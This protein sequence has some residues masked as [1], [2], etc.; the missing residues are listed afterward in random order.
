M[1]KSYLLL[2]AVIFTAMV[3]GQNQSKK[4]QAKSRL[5]CKP[6]KYTKTSKQVYFSENFDGN[7]PPT[8]WI[9]EPTTGEGQWVQDD[10]SS[11]G[12]GNAFEGASAAMFNNYYFSEGVEGSMTTPALDLST[13]TNPLLQ[14]YWWNNDEETNPASLIISI[15]TDGAT[16]TQIDQIDVFGCEETSWVRYQKNIDKNITHIKITGVSDYGYS[17]TFIDALTIEEVPTEAIAEL[18]ISEANFGW[19]MANTANNP[20]GN[21]FKL[22]NMGLTD[23]SISSITDLSGTDF[24]STFDQSVSLAL[25]ETHEF[26]FTYTPASEGDDAINFEIVTNGGTVSINLTGRGYE[27]TEGMVECGTGDLIDQGLPFYP[28]KNYSYTQSI[29]RQSE[30]NTANKQIEKLYYHFN[31]HSE[32]S[33]EITIYMGH[34]SSTMLNEWIP[35]SELTCVFEGEITT[36]NEDNFIEIT[37]Q[38]PFEYNNSDHLIIAI[39][40]NS[41]T[42]VS[43]DNHFYCHEKGVGSSYTVYDY[44]DNIDPAN[45]GEGTSK[46]TCANMRFQFEPIAALTQHTISGTI[47]DANNGNPVANATI[48]AGIFSTQTSAD[49]TY[50]LNVSE[51]DYTLK[52]IHEDF[53]VYSEDIVVNQDVSKS[54]ALI[55]AIVLLHEGFNNASIPPAGWSRFMRGNIGGLSFGWISFSYAYEGDFSMQNYDFA[56]GCDNWI[57]TPK[58]HITENTKLNYQSADAKPSCYVLISTG[59]PNPDDNQFKVLKTH[60]EEWSWTKKEIDLSEYAGMD[61]YIAFRCFDEPG[62]PASS[63]MVDDV[64]IIS[65]NPSAKIYGTISVSEGNTDLSKA[66][67]RIGHQNIQVNSDGSFESYLIPGTYTAS[68]KIDAYSAEVVENVSVS[69]DNDNKLDISLS[70]RIFKAPNGLNINSENGEFSWNTPLLKETQQELVYDNG[71]PDDAVTEMGA[72]FS[73]RLTPAAPGRIVSLKYATIAQTDTNTFDAVV[74]DWSEDIGEPTNKILFKQEYITAKNGD[75]SVVDL[76]NHNV[77][78][79]SDFVVCFQIWEPV[80]LLTD[81]TESNNRSW[82]GYT[83]PWELQE[84]SYLIRATIEYDNGELVEVTMNDPQEFVYYNVFL[85]DM[86]TSV[87]EEIGWNTTTFNNLNNG[88]TYTAGVQ[89]VY[90]NGVSEIATKEFTYISDNTTGI[91]GEVIL[92]ESGLNMQDIIITAGYAQTSPD[93]NGNYEFFLDPGTYTVSAY[94]PGYGEGK[95]EGVTVNSGNI[96]ENINIVIEELLSGISG[97]VE[98]SGIDANVQDVTVTAGEYTVN[99]DAAGNYELRIEPGTYNVS[100][101]LEGYDEVITEGVVVN[102][103]TITENIDFVIEEEIINSVDEIDYNDIKL[104]PNPAN[105]IL[106]ITAP[107]G[108]DIY[109]YNLIGGLVYQAKSKSTIHSVNIGHLPKG[110]YIVRIIKNENITTRKVNF[111]F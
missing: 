69:L 18:N 85:D 57:I 102:S 73:V 33:Q 74:I 88:R 100:A 17:S 25:G 22:S 62:N 71:I 12:P 23:L 61:I 50:S 39:D 94:L 92:S 28:K 75:W 72:Y 60:E 37:L 109:I 101:K 47:T 42:S 34:T 21:T 6:A 82:K 54:V 29:Y 32:F 40:E 9:L 98:L 59:S 16:F 48:K 110:T 91:S 7:F 99:P 27:L 96:T 24:S 106:N 35:A 107:T 83:G 78:V 14:F 86:E 51:G 44:N 15:S 58:V 63:W 4:P 38:K 68:A 55:K 1:K 93:E 11:Y 56:D 5:T 8:D 90:T 77:R 36:P 45:P 19:T 103:E 67:L 52:V 3:F 97:T 81:K 105:N 104:Y 43:E 41:P 95:V 2:L 10:C 111:S 87:E 30:L 64:N 53:S 46:S 79:E 108:S 89:A 20:W 65:E 31:G 84:E 13:A 76:S 26:G 80:A 66:Q 49:G 70:P